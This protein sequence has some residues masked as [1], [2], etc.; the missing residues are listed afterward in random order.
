MDRIELLNR[1]REKHDSFI[2]V[3]VD[4]GEYINPLYKECDYF[5]SSVFD[6]D[7]SM[8]EIRLCLYAIRSLYTIRYRFEEEPIQFISSNLEENISGMKEVLNHQVHQMILFHSISMKTTGTDLKGLLEEVKERI[9][10]PEKKIT[11][12]GEEYES[13]NDKVRKSINTFEKLVG[14]QKEFDV[15]NDFLKMKEKY[16]LEWNLW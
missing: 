15:V 8:E 9:S 6:A 16:G 2:K 11:C 14:H 12:S 5:Y 4:D 13:E 10:N 3:R 7:L 1:L